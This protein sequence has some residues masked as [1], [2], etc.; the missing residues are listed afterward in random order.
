[1]L[2]SLP[3]PYPS[4]PPNHQ[5]LH[6]V[7]ARPTAKNSAVDSQRGQP[8]RA[9]ASLPSPHTG[10][11]CA[12]L[13][14]FLQTLTH[15]HQALCQIFSFPFQALLPHLRPPSCKVQSLLNSS[16]HNSDHGLDSLSPDGYT[17]ELWLLC[18]GL[19]LTL[20]GGAPRY[21]ILVAPHPLFPGPDGASAHPSLLL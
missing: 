17:S 12:S 9:S 1:M 16:F 19:I 21:R 14:D 13:Q 6:C 18:S 20:P 5:P 11:G 4:V 15:Q 2:S 3:G 7:V 8:R 10:A